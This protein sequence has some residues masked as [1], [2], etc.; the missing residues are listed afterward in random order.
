MQ[1]LWQVRQKNTLILCPWRSQKL[2]M[3]NPSLW[4]SRESPC[5]FTRTA[6][7]IPQRQF[8]NPPRKVHMISTWGCM[9]SD[10][11]ERQ[12][13][14]ALAHLHCQVDPSVPVGTAGRALPYAEGAS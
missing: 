8:S 3:V 9:K 12:A 6:N 2:P 4:A 11:K 5:L 14:L 10:A 7:G 13:L 1:N